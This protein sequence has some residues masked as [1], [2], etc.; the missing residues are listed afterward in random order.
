MKAVILILTALVSTI[1]LG[2]AYEGSYQDEGGSKMLHLRRLARAFK[3][4]NPSIF[5]KRGF[6]KVEDGKWVNEKA[7]E[8]IYMDEEGLQLVFNDVFIEG[9]I[10]TINKVGL[11]VGRMWKRWWWFDY[12]MNFG[13][14]GRTECT[15]VKVAGQRLSLLATKDGCQLSVSKGLEDVIPLR[16]ELKED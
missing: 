13:E 6:V 16:V 8:T 7:K 4:Q 14:W 3:H 12:D 9:P 2:Q 5:E 10:T 1:G 11:L 15:T